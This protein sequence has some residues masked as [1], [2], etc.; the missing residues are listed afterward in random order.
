VG[1][2]QAFCLREAETIPGPATDRLAEAARRYGILIQLGLA[3]RALH[4]NV[5][6]NSTAQIHIPP[7][8]PKPQHET[9][10]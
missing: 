5:I 6:F 10:E 7:L 3:E 1:E 9:A 4:G 8:G 2:S